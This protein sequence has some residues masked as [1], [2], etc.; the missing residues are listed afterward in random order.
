[1]KKDDKRKIILDLRRQS[2]IEFEKLIVYIASGGLVLTITFSE[3]IISIDKNGNYLNWLI[4]TWIFFSLTLITSLIIHLTSRKTFDLYLAKEKSKSDRW[5][6]VTR[7]FHM[8]SVIILIF[9]ISSFVIYAI[10]S[11]HF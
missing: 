4:L 10:C 1:M 11:L 8:F 9:G 7:F 2:E 3:K 5:D 6:N